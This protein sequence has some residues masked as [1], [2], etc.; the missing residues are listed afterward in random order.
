MNRTKRVVVIGLLIVLCGSWALTPLWVNPCIPVPL[1]EEE[2]VQTREF[3]NYKNLTVEQQAKV[4]QLYR[5]AEIPCGAQSLPLPEKLRAAN[6]KGRILNEISFVTKPLILRFELVDVGEN[7]GTYY[8]KGY[9]F[10][11][12][13]LY[14]IFAGGSG[15]MEI[16]MLPFENDELHIGEWK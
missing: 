1:S 6:W 9:T 13:P 12:I 5:E 15:Y 4:D 14:R 8:F 7:G 10:F 11:Y 16:D 2:V 3:P